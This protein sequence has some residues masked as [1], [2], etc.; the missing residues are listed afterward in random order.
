MTVTRNEHVTVL[1]PASWAVKT[2]VEVPIG[3]AVP[4]VC[5]VLCVTVRFEEQL[6]VKDGVAKLKILLH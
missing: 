1:L 3:N 4:D 2:T 6:S 5:P